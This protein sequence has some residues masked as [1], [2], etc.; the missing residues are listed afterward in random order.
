M[1]NGLPVR[2]SMQASTLRLSAPMAHTLSPAAWAAWAWSSRAGSSSEARGG[3]CSMAGPSLRR[4]SE[5]TWP[6]WRTVAPKSSLWQAISPQPGVA[7]RL[8]A[9]AEETGRPLRGVVHAAGVTGDGI[10]AALTRDGLERVWAP[11]VAGA[12]AAARSDG[13]PTARLVGWLLFDGLAARSAGSNGVRDRER[14][15]RRPDGLATRIG[16]A[17]NHD[18]LGPVVGRRDEPLADL[19]RAGPDHS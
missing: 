7:E 16:L 9:A 11:K 3:S 10:V 8:V 1:S 5:A 6:T 17:R 15:A 14:V 4:V 19:Q 13:D 12:L 2:R 18:Q